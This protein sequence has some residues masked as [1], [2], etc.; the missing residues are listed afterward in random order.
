MTDSTE[1]QDKLVNAYDRMMERFRATVEHAGKDTL[2]VLREQIGAAGEKAVELG[3][4]TRE[5]AR[6]IAD[7]LQRDVED[8]GQFLAESGA[9]L[10]G[11]LRFDMGLI[12]QRLLE[13]FASAADHTKLAL[14]Q[15]EQQARLASEYHTGE[16]TGIGTLQCRQCGKL[17]HFHHTS[18]IPPCPQ[19]HATSFN[20]AQEG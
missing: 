8:A 4:L 5:E 1:E 7:Y 3:E 6:R 14:L 12:E 13:I 2:P 19:C 17:M 11:W 9:D 18:R 16:I 20:R 15:I 10:A